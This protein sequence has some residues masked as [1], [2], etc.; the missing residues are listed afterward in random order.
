MPLP[1]S[2]T[3]NRIVSSSFFLARI[4]ISDSF[5]E[6]FI[7]LLTRLTITCFMRSSSMS[8]SD[9]CSSAIASTLICFD[10]AGVFSFKERIP[11]GL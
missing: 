6:N 3:S 10:S 7:A 11:P 5:G 2:C 9:T 4:C 1:K 8:K